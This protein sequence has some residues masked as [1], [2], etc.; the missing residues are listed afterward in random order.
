MTEIDKDLFDAIMIKESGWDEGNPGNEDAE[1]DFD[2]D[3]V[4]HAIGPYQIWKRY[5]DDAVEK[6]PTLK[7]NGMKYENCKG[8]GSK[9]YSKKVVQAY[10]DRYATE[11]R[12]RRKVTS[13]DIARIHNGGPNGYDKTSTEAY[14]HAVEVI[15]QKV[16]KK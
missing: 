6:D 9:E 15:L 1:G 7:A 14:W 8:P 3:D 2:S 5:Y 4:P 13:E 16:K 12:L 10:M 11:A